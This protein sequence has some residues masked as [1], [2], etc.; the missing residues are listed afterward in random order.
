[1]EEDVMR[2]EPTEDEWTAAEERKALRRI[3]IEAYRV[4]FLEAVARGLG[5]K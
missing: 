5:L 3:R 1:M 4:R 2:W